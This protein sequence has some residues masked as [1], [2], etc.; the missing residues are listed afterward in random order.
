[1]NHRIRGVGTGIRIPINDDVL[2]RIRPPKVTI[3]GIIW[4][5]ATYRRMYPG[6]GTRIYLISRYKVFYDLPGKKWPT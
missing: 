3:K 4:Y 1:M 2:S 5:P 6:V